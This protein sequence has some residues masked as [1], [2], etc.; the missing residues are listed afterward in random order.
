MADLTKMVHSD[1]VG[2]LA[3]GT[4]GGAYGT[5]VNLTLDTEAEHIF[6]LIV[7]GVDP[8]Y[9][10]AEGAHGQLRVNSKSLG[11]NQE[12]F[13][14]GP[15]TT[16][17]PGTNGSGQAMIQEVIKV[18]WPCNGGETLSFD[19]APTNTITTARLYE[20]MVM[21]INKGARP[22]SDWID[23]FPDCVAFKGSQVVN[24]QQL[25]TT[26][27]ALANIVIPAWAKEIVAIKSII[28]KTG[29][30]TAGEE[31]LGYFEIQGT[32]RGIANQHYPTNGL[33]ATLG[34]PVG[35]G[36]YHDSLPWIPV[37][38]PM[39]GK[40]ETLT[41]WINLRTAITTDNQVHFAIAYR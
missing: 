16:S 39:K 20:V 29:A 22:P 7:S 4:T 25:T 18:D 32:I 41:P 26:R 19:V 2:A 23:K 6:A 34:T 31:C 12:L 33:G 14:V 11:I 38:I 24:A 36:M 1:R 9:T 15:Y 35:T 5:P 40:D 13:P 37:W 17:G 3:A 28:L 8:I 21:Y 27:T 10:T 30:I